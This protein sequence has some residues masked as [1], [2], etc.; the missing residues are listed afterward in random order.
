MV[1]ESDFLVFDWQ[2]V[3]CGESDALRFLDGCGVGRLV[4]VC[5]F[6]LIFD[7]VEGLLFF[8]RF[9]LVFE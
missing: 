6:D 5:G 3:V 7:F 9:D 1:I 8:D 2:N 4:F